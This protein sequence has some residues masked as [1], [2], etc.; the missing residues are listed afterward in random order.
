MIIGLA[1]SFGAGKGETVRGTVSRRC[2]VF[3]EF[4][5]RN[6]DFQVSEQNKNSF[7]FLGECRKEALLTRCTATVRRPLR[8]SVKQLFS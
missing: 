1:G 5:K 6:T 7:L 2:L 3:L 8:L 4:T